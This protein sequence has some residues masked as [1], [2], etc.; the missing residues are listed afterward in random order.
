MFRAFLTLPLLVFAVVAADP[1]IDPKAQ[2]LTGKL[3]AQFESA[4]TAEVELD[5]TVKLQAPENTTMPAKYSLA[6]EKPNRIA[7]VFTEGRIGA[8]VYSDGTNGTTF[9]PIL[10]KYTVRAAPKSIGAL[11]LEAGASFGDVTGS[12]AFIAALFSP[13]PYEALLEGVA[14]GTYGGLEVIAG[15][16]YQRLKFKQEGVSWSL[17]MTDSEK[18]LLYRIEFDVS[19]LPVNAESM[20]MEF[21][22]W[23]FDEKIAAAR[24]K[25]APPKDARKVDALLESDSDLVGEKLPEFKLKGIDGKTWNSTDWKGQPVILGF[26]AGAEKHS[27]GALKDLSDLALDHKQ[28]KIFTV[29]LDEIEDAAK[30][31]ALFATHKVS[32]PVALDSAHA[33]SEELEVDGVPMTFYIDKNGIIQNAWLGHHPDFKKLVVKEILRNQK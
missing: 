31:T 17:L 4:K 24:F 21:N 15:R 13:K 32:L 16:E 33:V 19:K 22:N 28:V 30:V 26:W 25:F 12:M 8:S 27:I 7:L 10:N 1:K 11:V 14:E 9:I 18:P 29:N 20:T 6:V 2:E 5:V 23:R 3:A